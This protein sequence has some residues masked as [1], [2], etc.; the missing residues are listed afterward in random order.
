LATIALKNAW[1]SPLRAALTALAVAITL[2]AF[3]L[4][5]TLSANWT[6]RIEQ[7]PDNRVVTRHKIGWGQAMPVHY[8]QQV[9]GLAGVKHAMGGRWAALKHPTNTRIWFDAT[10]VDAAPFAAMHYELAAPAEQ[11][12]AFVR[13]RRGMLVSAELA[14]AYGWKL[15]DAVHLS[16]TE[17]PGDWEFHVSGIYR[18]TRHGFAKRSIWIHWE[19]YNE[20][21]PPQERDLINIISAEIHRP[22]EGAGIARA[23]DIH[24]DQEDNQTY[25]QEDQAMHA[26]LVGRFGAVLRALDVVSLL[27]LSVI[28]LLVGNAMAMSVRERTQEYGILR[29]IGFG[30]AEVV[31]FVLLEAGALG[32]LGGALG[33]AA[34]FPLVE[35]GISPF[36]E[37][38]MDFWPLHVPLGPALVA[39]ALTA[40]LGVAAA[41]LPA[42]QASRLEVVEA[43]RHVG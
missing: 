14:A 33:L 31:L 29:A 9:R 35:R 16:G 24:F 13:D 17:F 27:V 3:L 28:L 20:R 10:A 34:A 40:L 7:T 23:I 21:L 4:L 32:L 12:Q 5:R 15:G 38:N 26:S 1:R 22:S 18:S 8:T 2:V 43:L 11:K 19:Y 30:R 6:E 36:L 39:P 41:I 42:Y 25:S 37:T